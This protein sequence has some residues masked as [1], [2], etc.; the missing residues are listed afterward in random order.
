MSGPDCWAENQTECVGLVASNQQLL[1]RKEN[2]IQ[3]RKKNVTRRV[4]IQIARLEQ[5]P[6]TKGSSC[7]VHVEFQPKTHC[8]R[9][10]SG[11][12]SKMISN[13]SAC[14]LCG[15]ITDARISLGRDHKADHTQLMASD[16]VTRSLRPRCDAA[17]CHVLSSSWPE[18]GHATS[19]ERACASSAKQKRVLV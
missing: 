6:S 10:C 2:Q 19:H 5:S 13:N 7:D 18:H 12:I 1:Q 14:D 9:V 16:C 8:F 15:R 17:R 3:H 11:Q 4:R